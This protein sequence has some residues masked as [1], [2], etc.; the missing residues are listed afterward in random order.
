ML[1]LE[2]SQWSK[3]SHLGFKY[4]AIKWRSHV[5][6]L[7]RLLYWSPVCFSTVSGIKGYKPYSHGLLR[8]TCGDAQL[9]ASC[10]LQ[11]RNLYVLAT[12]DII[13]RLVIQKAVMNRHTVLWSWNHDRLSGEAKAGST[14]GARGPTWL[15]HALSFWFCYRRGNVMPQGDLLIS[16]HRPVDLY[17]AGNAKD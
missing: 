7:Q 6:T 11:E 14:T 16:F 12:W 17:A 13:P 8:L 3:D 1:T 15:G 10:L 2:P 4:P 9:K 5:S